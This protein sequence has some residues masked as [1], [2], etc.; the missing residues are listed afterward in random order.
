MRLP[1]WSKAVT[2]PVTTMVC[3]STSMTSSEV[4]VA[5]FQAL[6]ELDHPRPHA[7]VPAVDP[8]G[9]RHAQRAV[10]IDQMERVVEPSMAVRLP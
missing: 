7:V 8:I 2:C 1:E 10:R 9:D 3:A 4:S 6:S 5:L